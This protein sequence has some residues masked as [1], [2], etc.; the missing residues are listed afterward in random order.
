M[1]QAALHNQNV[2]TLIG[3]RQLPAVT[4]AARCRTPVLGNEPRRQVR[5]FKVGEAKFLQGIQPVTPPTKELD[6][7][8]IPW[9]VASSELQQTR[10]KLLDLFVWRLIPQIGR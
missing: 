5:S 3:E 10:T 9:P 7:S 1:M 6:D 2:P 4:D 8:G